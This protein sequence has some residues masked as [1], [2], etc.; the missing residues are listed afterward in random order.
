MR[1]Q[2]RQ[3]SKVVHVEKKEEKIRKAMR[4]DRFLQLWLRIVVSS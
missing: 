2:V 4:L 1:C 3:Q